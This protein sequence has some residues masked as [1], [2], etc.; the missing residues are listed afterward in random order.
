MLKYPGLHPPKYSLFITITLKPD[1]KK[2]PAQFQYDSTKHIILSIMEKY[3]MRFAYLPELHEDGN[4]HYHGWLVLRKMSDKPLFLNSFKGKKSIGF[5]KI[6]RESI[7]EQD[8]TYEYIIKDYD[9][10]KQCI[11]SIEVFDHKYMSKIWEDITIKKQDDT[12][13][14]DYLIELDKLL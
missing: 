3:C 14:S 13:N 8:R 5:I 7:E 10:T 4:V 11:K 12:L 2:Y 9:T 6:N 1:I